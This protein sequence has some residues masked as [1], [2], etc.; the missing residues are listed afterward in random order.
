[1]N[2]TEI[3]KELFRSKAIAKFSH[4]NEGRLF[5]NV[6]LESGLHQFPIS[7]IERVNLPLEGEDITVS[8]IVLSSDLGTTSFQNEIKASELNRWIGKAIDKNQFINIF[9]SKQH[10]FVYLEKN[11]NDKTVMYVNGEIHSSQG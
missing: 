11:E 6:Q 4:Y 7:V 8:A 1:M 2:K 9:P 3:Q 5:Y 10:D